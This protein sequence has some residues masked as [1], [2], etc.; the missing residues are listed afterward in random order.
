MH[1][2]VGLSGNAFTE[3]ATSGHHS[4]VFGGVMVGSS[5]IIANLWV[6]VKLSPVGK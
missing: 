5:L 3:M 4:V 1:Q 2:A 6:L